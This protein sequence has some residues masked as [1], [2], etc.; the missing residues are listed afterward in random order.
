[1]LLIRQFVAFHCF[2][3]KWHPWG[4]LDAVSVQSEE[5]LESLQ[6]LASKHINSL[7]LFVVCGSLSLIVFTTS[8]CDLNQ[9]S[10]LV[11]H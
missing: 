10:L 6:E 4:F 3:L 1:V 11:D 9:T 8:F 5:Y 7:V 2:F